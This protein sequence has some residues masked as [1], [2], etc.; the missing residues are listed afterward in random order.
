MSSMEAAFFEKGIQIRIRDCYTDSEEISS[1]AFPQISNLHSIFYGKE[2]NLKLPIFQ[3]V[4]ENVIR[5][6]N[7]CSD[8]NTRYNLKTSSSNN[9]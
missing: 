3:P 4:L 9:V 5:L 7:V 6:T 1:Q 2:S 8:L